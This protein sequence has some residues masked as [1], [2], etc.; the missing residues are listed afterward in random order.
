MVKSADD[1]GLA[2]EFAGPLQFCEAR[3]QGASQPG[4]VG[5]EGFIGG[6]VQVAA[7]E[8]TVG[9]IGADLT[10]IA[11]PAGSIGLQAQERSQLLWREI[12][13]VEAKRERVLRLGVGH[14]YGQYRLAEA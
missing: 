1:I 2:A 7:Q 12:I 4:E 9:W 14:R 6:Q 8:P 5:V 3:L 10:G 13:A 11:L